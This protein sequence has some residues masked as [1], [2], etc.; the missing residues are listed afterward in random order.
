[1]CLDAGL[2]LF[3]VEK[4]LSVVKLFYGRQWAWFN[5][6]SNCFLYGAIES[7]LN[8]FLSDNTVTSMRENIVYMADNVLCVACYI[9]QNI[10]V[11]SI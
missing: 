7:I 10:T 1:M 2:S 6:G 4:F 11:S 8:I 5:Q 3:E 9:M